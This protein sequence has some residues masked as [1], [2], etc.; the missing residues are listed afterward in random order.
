MKRLDVLVVKELFSP[1]AFGVAIF[2]VLIMAGTYLFKITEYVVGGVG[3]SIV[4]QLSA[5]LLPGVMAKTF[6]MAMLLAALLAFGRLSGDSEIVA[7]RA[8]GASLPRIMLPV[9]LFG[10]AVAAVAFAFNELLVPVA[11]LRATH[12]QEEINTRLSGASWRSLQYP[13]FQEGKLQ[14]IVGAQNFEFGTRELAGAYVI[15]YDAEHDPVYIL[16]ADRLVFNGETDWR[17][18]GKAK[19]M[20]ADGTTQVTL[21]EG[22]WPNEIPKI[23]A[24]PRAF[25]ASTLRDLD[26][27]SMSQMREQI[28]EAKANPTFDPAQIANLEYGFYNK[29]ALPAAAIVYALVGAPLGIR[30]HRA[31]T[32]SG[33]WMSVLIIFC[34]ISLANLMNIYAQGGKIHASVASFTPLVI[35]LMV[36][37]FTIWRKN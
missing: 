25:I 21:S 36:A 14:A 17:I 19:L 20:A 30:N 33:F 31:S 37:A 2:T 5:L 32:A 18:K 12:L 34:Y 26:A 13:I 28:N 10:L 9:G 4:L 11:A 15:T 29:I 1:W 27:L 16:F 35:G 23:E 8:T 6:P 24:D 22:A 3:A 7:M